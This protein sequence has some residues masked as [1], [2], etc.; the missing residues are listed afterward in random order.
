MAKIARPRHAL[1]LA[2][3]GQGLSQEQLAAVAGSTPRT[4]QRAEAGRPVLPHTAAQLARALGRSPAAL[5]LL[6]RGRV[7]GGAIANRPAPIDGSDAVRRRQAL[8]LVSAGGTA[9]AWSVSHHERDDLPGGQPHGGAPGDDRPSDRD[10][11]RAFRQADP[12]LGGGHVYQAVVDYLERRVAPRLFGRVPGDRGPDVFCLAATLTDMAGWMAHDAGQDRLA[13]QHFARALALARAGGDPALEANILASRTHLALQLGRPAE[14]L[15]LARAGRTALRRGGRHPGLEARLYALEAHSSAGLREGAEC[16]RLLGRAERALAAPG[17]SPPSEWTSEFD[18]GSL[19]G[20]AAQALRRLGLLADARGHAERV[21]VLR[22]AERVR[23]R[24]FG[25]LALAGIHA[26]RRELD[27]ACAVG[28][29]VLR[30][31]AA[32]GSVRV[33]HQLHGLRALLRPH[34]SAPVVGR[35]LARSADELRGRVALYPWLAGGPPPPPA[36]REATGE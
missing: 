30:K 16:V 17:S 6:E 19:A 26:E 10:F 20:E 24:A 13:D 2:R 18:E 33:V 11:L 35:F 1:R 15:A 5:G 4:V 21:L 27:Q 25:Q 28:Q 29:D 12:Q 31:T 32:L 36:S 3:L 7:T 23:S 34:R 22:P 14:A 9:W 8:E